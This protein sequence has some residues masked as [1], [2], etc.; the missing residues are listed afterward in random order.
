M[1]RLENL[2]KDKIESKKDYNRIEQEKMDQLRS[3][4]LHDQF[5][6]DTDDKKSLTGPPAFKSGSCRVRFSWLL[7]CY[8]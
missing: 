4:K 5:G 6:R 1:G 2:G 7:L 3:T 8:K